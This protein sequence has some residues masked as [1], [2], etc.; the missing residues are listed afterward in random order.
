[1]SPTRFNP[2]YLIPLV[3][4]VGGKSTN[5]DTI[6]RARAIYDSLGMHPL[7]VK[8]EIEA[9]SPIACSKRFG[10]NHSGW[11]RMASPLHRMSTMRFASDLDCAGHKWASSI[12]TGL[13]AVRPVCV[14]LWLSS[15]LV[16]KWPWTKLMDVPE[17][18]DELVDMIA[19]QS[20]DQSGHIGIRDM[21][22]I[23]DD[24]LVAICRRSRAPTG[25]QV[26][27]WPG[28]NSN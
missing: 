11:S 10:A 27:H 15:A 24:N 23:R 26:K 18:N 14:I 5:A 3:E 8:K 1:M 22:R 13:P 17:F 28:T 7:H 20:D 6:A 21:E 12:P 9:L 16:L 4:L 2:V 19:G 25:E